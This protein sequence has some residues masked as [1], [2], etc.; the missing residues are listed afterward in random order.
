M[1][2]A[3]GLYKRTSDVDA[4]AVARATSP[5][6]TAAGASDTNHERDDH[7]RDDDDM[8]GARGCTVPHAGCS[9]FCVSGCVAEYDKPGRAVCTAVT[10]RLRELGAPLPRWC[11]RH[12]AVRC[13][14]RHESRWPLGVDAVRTRAAAAHGADGRAACLH[15]PCARGRS[16]RLVPAKDHADSQAPPPFRA[17]GGRVPRDVRRERGGDEQ[18][19]R[20]EHLVWGVCG[21]RCARQPPYA[22][23]AATS[24]ARGRADAVGALCHRAGRGRCAVGRSQR[25]RDGWGAPPRG[26]CSRAAGW[27]S[28]VWC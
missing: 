1:M 15:A 6:D 16:G 19:S 24:R 25:C 28:P 27:R 2:T 4:I 10:P 12:H 13:A 5:G 22:A 23:T 21:Y 8:L 3:E 9:K 20:S 11:A 14:C 17:R 18:G 7:E 26:V